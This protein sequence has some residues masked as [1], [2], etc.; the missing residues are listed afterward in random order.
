M[1]LAHWHFRKQ[2]NEA[3]GC[4]EFVVPLHGSEMGSFPGDKS[5]SCASRATA[6]MPDLIQHPVSYLKWVRF[7][8]F[9]FFGKSGGRFGI[10]R[11]MSQAWRPCLMAL[12]LAT[13]LPFGE[14]GPVDFLALRRLAAICFSL[15]AM[16]MSFTQGQAA[17]I[18]RDVVG[19][20]YCYSTIPQPAA[21][22]G[23][24]AVL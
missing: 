9:R 4:Q 21:A 19:K 22:G 3:L 18:C 14:R 1:G 6:V 17:A 7:G 2:M 12:R 13:D 24:P 5:L 15:A 8:Y 20:V 11:M 23:P 16:S 10:L